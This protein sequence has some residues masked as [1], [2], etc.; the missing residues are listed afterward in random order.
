MLSGLRRSNL[1]F[2]VSSL[3]TRTFGLMMSF[4]RLSSNAQYFVLINSLSLD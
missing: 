4:A 1:I 2:T 3:R